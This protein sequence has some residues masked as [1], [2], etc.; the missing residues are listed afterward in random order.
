M[1]QY[2][3]RNI[4]GTAMHEVQLELP[5]LGGGPGKGV[6]LSLLEWTRR[7]LKPPK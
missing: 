1:L 3:Y 6:D 5:L 7:P 2:W 4:G